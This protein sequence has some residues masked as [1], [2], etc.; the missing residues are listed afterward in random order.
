[1]KRLTVTSV[2]PALDVWNGY[3]SRDL[4]TDYRRRPPMW[5]SNPRGWTSQP[6]NRADLIALAEARGFYVVVEEGE[7]VR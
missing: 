1:M 7:V 5:C 3:G 4:L 6:A 2:T